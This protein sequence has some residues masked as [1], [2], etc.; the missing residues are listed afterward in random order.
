MTKSLVHL[1]GRRSLG[2]MLFYSRFFNKNSIE[3]HFKGNNPFNRDFIFRVSSLAPKSNAVAESGP[4]GCLIGRKSQSTK[5]SLESPNVA[6]SWWTERQCMCY[7]Y[8]IYYFVIVNREAIL[9]IGPRVERST[10]ALPESS[11]FGHSLQT[12][13][14]RVLHFRGHYYR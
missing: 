1:G 14:G 9:S 11:I 12:V 7:N 10:E 5:T 2:G 8:D 6:F 4:N 3:L 13:P